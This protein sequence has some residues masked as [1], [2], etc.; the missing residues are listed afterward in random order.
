MSV[1]RRTVESIGWTTTTNAVYLALM[2]LRSVLLARWLPVEIFGVYV[3]ARAFVEVTALLPDWGMGGAFLHRADAVSDENRAATIHFTLKLL[4]SLAWVGALLVFLVVF[5]LS[6]DATALAVIIGATWVTHLS[7]TPRL[8]LQRRIAFRRLAT[9]Q[10]ATGLIGTVV[11]LA[12]GWQAQITD[13]AEWALWALLSTHLINAAV[14]F[15]LLYGW[16]PP[17]RPRLGW[18]RE[19]VRYFVTFGG[20]NFAGTYLMRV[21]DRIDDL[22]TQAYLGSE[23]LGFY[24]RAFVFAGYPRELIARPINQVTRSTFAELKRDRLAL[25]RAFFR[26]TALLIRAGFFLA[27]LLALLAPEMITLL[28]TEKWTPMVPVFQL[29]LVYSM[30]DPLRM[31]VSNLMVSQG[32]PLRPIPV[33]LLQLL[34]LVLGLLIL[35]PRWGIEGVAMAVNFMVIIAVIVFFWQAR[36]Y[37]DYSLRRLFIIPGG[38]L[39][40]AFAGGVLAVMFSDDA[41]SVWLTALLKG[42]VFVSIFGAI[43]FTFERHDILS[44]LRQIR[45]RQAR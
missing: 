20:Q 13:S 38:A 6:L 2:L 39:V 12:I 37:V 29:M 3:A 28:L 16:R 10:V 26:S 25:S 30:L 18:S 31:T 36:R 22:W 15:L 8:V 33:R 45:S 17:W 4:F 40:A 43:L 42:V 9:I 24:S 1:V 5:D 32:D 27:G 19:I 35:G 14:G 44:M 34:L 7:Q 21:I 11:A 23:A 41:W